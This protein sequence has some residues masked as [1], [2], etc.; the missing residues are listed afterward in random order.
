MK[1]ASCMR[2]FRKKLGGS[3]GFYGLSDWWLSTVTQE[4]RQQL[5][6][7]YSKTTAGLQGGSLIKGRILSSSQHVVIFLSS[8]AIGK[9]KSI[10]E[11]IRQ[12]MK[13]VAKESPITGPG[14]YKGL[15]FTCYV[16]DV[17]E[18]KREGRL[19]EAEAL[20]L[21]LVKATEAESKKERLGVAP[22][23]YEQLA[24][25]YR[26]LKDYTSEVR[27]L[28]RYARHRHAPGVKPAVLEKRLQRAKSLLS[29]QN[30]R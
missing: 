15:H 5:E 11:R 7:A 12:K 24:I 8:L 6:K 23:Y 27:I 13:E 16:E 2:L 26:K 14:S 22:W 25:I 17:K 1:G 21:E 3:I 9:E 10:A 29:A 4:E 18:L 19:Q 20:L 28:E 30:N